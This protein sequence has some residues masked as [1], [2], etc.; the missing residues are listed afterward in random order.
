MLQFQKISIVFIV[1]D[2][3]YEESNSSQNEIYETI[4]LIYSY[5]IMHILATFTKELKH[6]MAFAG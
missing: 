1:E 3:F 6:I 5:G 4:L 2:I